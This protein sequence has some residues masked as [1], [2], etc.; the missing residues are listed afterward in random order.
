[1]KGIIFNY[2]E[3]FTEQLFGEFGWDGLVEDV[4]LKT[5]DG[6]FISP[7]LYPDEDLIDIVIKICEK[8]EIKIDDGVFKFGGFLITKFKKDYPNFFLRSTTAKAFLLSVHDVIHVE[9]KKMHYNANPPNFKYIN[10]EP[11]S[12]GMIY[13]S[14]RGL[15][16]LAKGMIMGLGPIFSEEISINE[17]MCTKK[18]H[19]HCTMIINFEKDLFMSN[20]ILMRL[21]GADNIIL[22]LNQKL[23]RYKER[24]RR[25]SRVVEEKVRELFVENEK[26]KETTHQLSKAQVESNIIFSNITE[27]LFLIDKDFNIGAQYSSSLEKIFD[28]PKLAGT[29]FVRLM[30]DVLSKADL[31][32]TLDYLKVKFRHDIE[33]KDIDELNPLSSVDIS[34]QDST[35]LNS[36]TK[37][38]SINT[39][40]IY[41]DGKVM[42]LLV[43]VVDKTDETLLKTELE[44]A[45]SKRDTERETLQVLLKVDPNRIE[46][47]LS[48]LRDYLNS[49]NNI[50]KRKSDNY[51]SEILSLARVVHKIK[52]LSSSVGLKPITKICHSVEDKIQEMS[53]QQH[54]SGDDFLS[55]V[56]DLKKFEV[57]LADVEASM[58]QLI[59]YGSNLSLLSKQ[60]SAKKTP[61]ISTN[62]RQLVGHLNT[63][64]GLQVVLTLDNIT[65]LGLQSIYNKSFLETFIQLIRNS[66][67][68][69]FIPKMSLDIPKN[70][71]DEILI[72]VKSLRG[73][74]LFVVYEDNGCGINID[75]LREKIAKQKMI[76][77]SEISK[78]DILRA[79]FNSS[80]S[81]TDE[82]Q[83]D[84]LSGRGVGLNIVYKNIKAL[85]G[86]L[87]VETI[88]NKLFRLKIT[89]PDFKQIANDNVYQNEIT[90]EGKKYADVV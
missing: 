45:N 13:E 29:N 64:F 2:L 55:L 48:L 90:K 52:G 68:H 16:S 73:G 36:H 11:F 22:K 50:L 21:S 40:R 34:V 63:Q 44:K 61:S 62:L 83:I 37:F 38:L 88:H 8:A 46:E 19:E 84:E 70:G 65:N 42:S 20:N 49:Y 23:S 56:I 18:G 58:M 35:K 9:V 7:E 59:N 12:L 39:F 43:N 71:K 32:A 15:C 54:L 5:S 89:I 53:K 24:E 31:D 47:Y 57:A 27:G 17:T 28:R 67:A 78:A 25:L 72:Q 26:L 6:I 79:I 3:E 60:D 74:G 4:T 76:E 75:V 69:G 82:T 41:G 85:G 10:N 51:S 87:R 1:M 86:Q 80:L 30:E 33:E 81:S 66:F 77:E 14:E